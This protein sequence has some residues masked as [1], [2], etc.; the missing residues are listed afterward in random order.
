VGCLPGAA[1][2]GGPALPPGASLPCSLPPPCQ[3]STAQ[4]GP[5][6]QQEA[7]QAHC[8][9]LQGGT[10]SRQ[11]THSEFRGHQQCIHQQ[12]T[13]DGCRQAA[14]KHWERGVLSC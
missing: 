12:S 14:S 1:P 8:H 11:H 7:P 9:P 6:G 10:A 3:A 5:Q 4:Q 2:A 13:E